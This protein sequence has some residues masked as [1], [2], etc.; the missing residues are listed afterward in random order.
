MFRLRIA[1]ITVIILLT[2]GGI[3]PT[4]A[5]AQTPDTLRISLSDTEARAMKTSLAAV[6]QQYNIT[7][8]EALIQQ[9]KLWDNP[10]AQITLPFITGTN[11]GTG[12]KVF[13]WGAGGQ[14]VQQI[15]QIFRLAG[16]RNKQ[17]ALATTTV[18]LNEYQ[19][20]DLLRTLRY[21][22]RS[23]FFDLYYAQRS[24]GVYRQEINS[25]TE[26]VRAF[27]EQFKKGNLAAKEVVRVKA[28]LYALQN[29]RQQIIQTITDKEADLALL[30]QT[31]TAYLIP[32]PPPA[33][34]NAPIPTVTSASIPALLDT[35]YAHRFDLQAAGLQVK[36]NE[37]NVALQKAL[38]V[39][40]LT[41]GIYFDRAGD[42]VPN[43]SAFTLSMDLP[44][45]NRNQGNIRA[46]EAQVKAADATREQTRR[47]VESD[48]ERAYAKALTNEQF[49]ATLDPAFQG[50]FDALIKEVFAGY[51]KHLISLLEFLDF[52]DSYKQAVLQQNQ[53]E[54]S[55]RDALEQL[56]FALGKPVF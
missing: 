4:I 26:T 23:T 52:Y 44:V 35:A 32:T 17:V 25:L 9:A 24:L 49:A 11:E 19:L 10:T 1:F 53:L 16:K 41:A 5:T 3:A 8:A 51:Q 40:D 55:H 36:Y 46:A 42:F 33:P 54:N 21:T 12:V 50:Q 29:E 34:A 6:A 22:A 39:P 28:Q 47:Q 30:L 7:S 43:Y 15:S 20:Y 31:K 48:V 27:D 14:S 2:V 13:P 18:K 37:Q 45:L 38:A 56:N